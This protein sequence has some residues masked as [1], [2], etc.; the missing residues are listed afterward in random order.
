MICWRSW[1]T[2]VCIKRSEGNWYL[3]NIIEHLLNI[4]RYCV[5]IYNTPSVKM[6][7]KS[8]YMTH[9]LEWPKS[10]TLTTPSTGEGVKQKKTFI[11]CWW[12][13]RMVQLLGKTVG[14]F[15]TKPSILSPYNPQIMPIMYLPK[16]TENLFPYKKLPLHIAYRS[17]AHNC[18]N[19]ESTKVFFRQQMDK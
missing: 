5:Y 8:I 2:S 13:C 1:V 11:H 3:L 16:W 7:S 4:C 15:L 14:H 18:Q 9:L 10:R 17:L 6:I 19:S 12:E